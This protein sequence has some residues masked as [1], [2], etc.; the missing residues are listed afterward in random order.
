MQ[1]EISKETGR[2]VVDIRDD[3]RDDGALNMSAGSDA[4]EMQEAVEDAVGELLEDVSDEEQ[5]S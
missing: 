4:D 5:G 1:K 3:I 2:S